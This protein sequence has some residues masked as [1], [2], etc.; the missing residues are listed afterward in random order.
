[1]S[2]GLEASGRATGAVKRRT[3]LPGRCD[4]V[5]VSSEGRGKAAPLPSFFRSFYI[6]PIPRHMSVAE[7]PRFSGTSTG[8]VNRI[9][10]V[11]HRTTR[12]ASGLPKTSNRIRRILS[13]MRPPSGGEVR[14]SVGVRRPAVGRGRRR[15]TLLPADILWRREGARRG[16]TGP[17]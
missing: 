3:T 1:M 7:R 15:R 11:R 9:V 14:C 13:R 10:A 2:D 12:A 16:E 5:R 8:R 17:F 6:E 4:L